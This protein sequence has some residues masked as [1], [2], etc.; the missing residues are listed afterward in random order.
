[1]NLK[2]STSNDLKALFDF[3]TEIT[4]LIIIC[5]I[6]TQVSS[7]NVYIVIRGLFS[8]LKRKTKGKK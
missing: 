7:L 3:L 1:M 5:V 8:L 2:Q 4:I 6:T